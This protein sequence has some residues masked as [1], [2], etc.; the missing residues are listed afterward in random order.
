MFRTSYEMLMKSKKTSIIR[1]SLGAT[2]RSDNRKPKITGLNGVGR[3]GLTL[4]I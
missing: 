1:L 2:I 3:V 4:D